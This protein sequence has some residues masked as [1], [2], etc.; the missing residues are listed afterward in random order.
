MKETEGSECIFGLR[1][2]HRVLGS[3]TL[4]KMLGVVELLEGRGS[5]LVLQSAEN[6]DGRGDG[7]KY[8]KSGACHLPRD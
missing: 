4:E 6:T 5:L 3:E 8:Q 7:S 2:L 1:G